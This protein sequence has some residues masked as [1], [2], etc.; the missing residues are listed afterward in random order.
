MKDIT[1]YKHDETL[2]KDFLQDDYCI[3]TNNINRSLIIH[4][5]NAKELDD[6]ATRLSLYSLD[7]I[8][9]KIYIKLK[10]H[11]SNEYFDEKVF[12]SIYKIEPKYI[13]FEVLKI[14]YKEYLKDN[15]TLN[16][17]S[18]LIF[19]CKGLEADFYTM[20]KE[21]ISIYQDEIN[22]NIMSEDKNNS[23]DLTTQYYSYIQELCKMVDELKEE[24]TTKNLDL[25]KFEEI[26]VKIYNNSIILTN[27]ENNS[28]ENQL[29]DLLAL[30]IINKLNTKDSALKT[31]MLILVC[32]SLLKTERVIFHTSI[33]QS[34]L[35][36]ILLFLHDSKKINKSLESVSFKKC[37][38]CHLC[39]Y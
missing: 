11:L 6:L 17:N 21:Y 37:N 14:I 2:V 1:I 18:F 27:K 33:Q 28:L 36:R 35:E 32:I 9:N 5:K 4:I 15:E 25:T 23:S 26:H 24:S 12:K 31:T 3:T 10:N 16:L 19:N 20:G 13:Y 29:T 8:E 7:Y 30:N 34:L 22:S 39:Y 38:G